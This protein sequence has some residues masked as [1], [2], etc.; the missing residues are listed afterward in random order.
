MIITVNEKTYCVDRSYTLYQLKNEYQPLADM[1]ILNG[2]VTKQDC[3]IQEGDRIVMISKGESPSEDQMSSLLIHRHSSQIHNSLNKAVIGIAGLGGLG[4]HVA[5]ALTRI[6]IGTLV[7]C[8]YDVVE[9]SN[10]NRQNYFIH[11]IGMKKTI[12]TQDNLLQM[13]PY[14]KL[15]THDTYLNSANI[16][17]IFKDVDIVVEAL[18]LPFCK[19]ELV[20]YILKHMHETKVVA[21]SGLAGYDTSNTIMTRKVNERLFIC[22]DGVSKVSQDC[23]LMAPRVGITAN[24][25]ANMV[26]RLI[27]GKQ[28]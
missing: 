27:L 23:C 25:Q 18:D 9:P 3:I 4:S 16:G 10:L 24:H 17:Q 19:A 2:R 15:I 6:G 21:A 20:N 12:A 5:A 8:D 22:G 13:H 7:L 28:E 1:L 11:Q 14:L 26:L